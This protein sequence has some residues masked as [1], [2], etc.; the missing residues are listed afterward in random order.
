MH[1]LRFFS[2]LAIVAVQA[3]LCAGQATA[4]PTGAKLILI[5]SEP[6]S[7]PR[8]PKH[9]GKAAA[10]P[11]AEQQVRPAILNLRPADD[12]I[13][14]EEKPEAETEPWRTYRR[15]RVDRFSHDAGGVALQGYD[16][17][18]Y[19]DDRVE[20]GV[21]E[22]S[23]DYGGV[24]WWFTSAGHRDSFAGDPVRYVPEYG[25]FCAY[26]IGRGYPATADPRSYL[27]AGG[28]LL[29]FYDRVVR[30]VWEQD[31]RLLTAKADR[32]WPEV[33]R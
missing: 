24:T 21:K 12:P 5:P 8:F 26:A 16:V 3:S 22:L 19:L 20:K 1:I 18:G 15:P 7:E 11:E 14:L 23:F 28:K 10:K 30:A 31:Q 13:Y 29:L 25:G 27:V 2:G 32:N 6:M 4:P 33:H 9:G 17:V